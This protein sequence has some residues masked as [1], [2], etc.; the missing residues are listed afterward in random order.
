MQVDVE[1]GGNIVD[2]L[3]PKIQQNRS[4]PHKRNDRVLVGQR[5]FHNPE[6]HTAQ[7][8]GQQDILLEFAG[9]VG[10]GG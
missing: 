4:Y 8:A 10:D 6:E 1:R 7:N 5:Q 9:D 3:L 2:V